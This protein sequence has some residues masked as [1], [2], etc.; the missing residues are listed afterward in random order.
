M[1]KFVAAGLALGFFVPSIAYAKTA[2]E[3]FNQTCSHVQ[4]VAGCTPGGQ[5]LDAAG[6][7]KTSYL[8]VIFD[9]FIFAVGIIAVIFLVIGGIRYITSTGDSARIKSAKDTILYAI[10]GLIVAILALPI[11][12][13]VIKT[14]GG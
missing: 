2:A 1:V 7:A 14:V 5:T 12:A 10:I 9:T 6:S 13:Y 8:Q 11:S 3:I 4:N